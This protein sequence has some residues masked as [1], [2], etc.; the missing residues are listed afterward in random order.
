MILLLCV[1]RVF[2]HGTLTSLSFLSPPIPSQVNPPS[3]D[4][5]SNLIVLRQLNESAVLHTLRWRYRW[6]LVYTNA[7]QNLVCI[8]PASSG[9]SLDVSTVSQQLAWACC[10]LFMTSHTVVNHTLALARLRVCFLELTGHN[11]IEW[12]VFWIFVSPAAPYSG[13][14]RGGD[15]SPWDHF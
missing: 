15:I 3:N 12:H 11:C 7:G 14:Q 10:R 9:C 13:H 1:T 4:T 5:S 8:N 6:G 2:S